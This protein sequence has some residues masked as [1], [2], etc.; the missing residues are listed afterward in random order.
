MFDFGLFFICTFPLPPKKVEKRTTFVQ[1]KNQGEMDDIFHHC[2]SSR[3]RTHLESNEKCL[4][5]PWQVWSIRSENGCLMVLTNGM[6]GFLDTDFFCFFPSIFSKFS[7]PKNEILKSQYDIL[8]ISPHK[9]V[10]L[11]KHRMRQNFVVL[12]LCGLGH[13]PKGPTMKCT[14]LLN[15]EWIYIK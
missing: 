15:D 13:P 1:R 2:R 4:S 12:C 6:K 10:F 5:R 3:L 14:L 8:S 9:H 11:K 7:S